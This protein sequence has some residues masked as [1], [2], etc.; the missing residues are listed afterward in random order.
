VFYENMTIS[1]VMDVTK[2]EGGT[3]ALVRELFSQLSG[4]KS[5]FEL[6]SLRELKV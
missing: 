6:L 4:S 5:R 3:V 2:Y 1:I